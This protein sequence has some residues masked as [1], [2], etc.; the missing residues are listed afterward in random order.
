MKL[1][2]RI[3][4]LIGD[5][6]RW[7]TLLWHHSTLFYPLARQF[8][9]YLKTCQ[10]IAPVHLTLSA[11]IKEAVAQFKNQGVAAFATT[12]TT[13]LAEAVLE[14]LKAEENRGLKVLDEDGRYLFDSFKRFPEFGKLFNSVVGEFLNG[15]LGC[16]YSIYYSIIYKSVRKAE[17]PMG[18][19]LWHHD[20][21]PGTCINLMFCLS[22]TSAQNG[23]MKTLPWGY[24]LEIFRKYAELNSRIKNALAINPSLTKMQVRTIKTDYFKEQIE[25]SYVHKVI[26]PVGG[27]G[28]VY[29]FKNNCI[30]AGG[31]PD[32][33]YERYVCIFHI[34]PS[35]YP[36]NLAWYEKYGTKKRGPY[37][38][39]PDE[40]DRL[41][42]GS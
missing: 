21:G 29:A 15:V 4:N 24:S 1:F 40:I 18:S 20:G 27:P 26:Q 35:K 42:F 3:R 8:S 10:R 14:Q 17:E 12:E 33:G 22:E 36:T 23:A 28:I 5:Q 38:S 9:N 30:H 32:I 37:P 19:A 2:S 34:Y 11:P 41:I 16:H 39:R 25:G 13:L 31:F 6:L 7:Y